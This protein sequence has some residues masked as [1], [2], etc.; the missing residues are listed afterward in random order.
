[1]EMT[2][3]TIVDEAI[4]QTYA[5]GEEVVVEGTYLYRSSTSNGGSSRI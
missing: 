4:E 3:K 2:I 1:M 5:E